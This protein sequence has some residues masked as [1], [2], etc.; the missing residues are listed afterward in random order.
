MSKIKLYPLR[1]PRPGR[2]QRQRSDDE[3]SLREWLACGLVGA[4]AGL[5]ILYV[6]VQIIS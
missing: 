4:V 6:S 3:M 2:I 5:G 1:A